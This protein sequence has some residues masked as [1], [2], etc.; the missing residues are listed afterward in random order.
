MTASCF[1]SK[2][3]ATP[4]KPC[5]PVAS[6][7]H[8]KQHKVLTGFYRLQIW[9]YSKRASRWIA[10]H[11]EWLGRK[12]LC[13]TTLTHQA[14]QAGCYNVLQ[15]SSPVQGTS[16]G[17]VVSTRQTF[18]PLTNTCGARRVVR[19]A[20]TCNHFPRHGMISNSRQKR[21]QF[22]QHHSKVCKNT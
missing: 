15:N 12:G 19:L 8:Y 1:I 17:T 14:W 4:A 11:Q 2:L 16:S 20:G 7:A 5:Y 18:E 6:A 21:K 22:K 3:C 9:S 13:K 10:W